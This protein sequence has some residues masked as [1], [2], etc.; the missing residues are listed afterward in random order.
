MFQPTIRKASALFLKSV[1]LAFFQYLRYL[2]STVPYNRSLAQKE[3]TMNPTH[4]PTGRGTTESNLNCNETSRNKGTTLKLRR[5]QSENRGLVSGLNTEPSPRR[6]R[7]YTEGGARKG[8]MWVKLEHLDGFCKMLFCCKR[9]RT[10]GSLDA[11][12]YICLLQCRQGLHQPHARV[13]GELRWIGRGSKGE[14]GG[15]SCG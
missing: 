5:P 15:A 4:S 7:Q 1:K 8:L 3:E 14:G 12:E 9:G 2:P 6:D 11:S 13:V 10:A